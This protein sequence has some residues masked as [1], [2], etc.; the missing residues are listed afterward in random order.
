MIGPNSGQLEIENSQLD[1]GCSGVTF[2]LFQW[3]FF[4]Q[5]KM[6]FLGCASSAGKHIL[7]F[8]FGLHPKQIWNVLVKRGRLLKCNRK[9]TANPPKSDDKNVQEMFVHSENKYFLMRS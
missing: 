8:L 7:F 5:Y 6:I 4:Q 2:D 1:Q 9:A 3:W